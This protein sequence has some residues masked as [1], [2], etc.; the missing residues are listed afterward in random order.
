MGLLG[1]V[2]RH[3]GVS[4]L[5]EKPVLEGPGDARLLDYVVDR[6]EGGR[7]VVVATVRAGEGS[8]AGEQ[9]RTTS[10]DSCASQEDHG[11]ITGGKRRTYAGTLL[12]RRR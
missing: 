5:L 1:A 9:V 7:A 3:A 4:L 6:L 10:V 8:P 12:R 2:V 11:C